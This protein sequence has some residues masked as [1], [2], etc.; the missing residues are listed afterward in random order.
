MKHHVFLKPKMA[1]QIAYTLFITT[2]KGF[3]LCRLWFWFIVPIFHIVPLTFPV[4]V[5]IAMMFALLSYTPP[6]T[7]HDYDEE[8]QQNIM[9]GLKPFLV[10]GVGWIVHLFM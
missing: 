8:Y 7:F 5:G 2:I 4:G 10:L 6:W 3:V 1:F 9:I